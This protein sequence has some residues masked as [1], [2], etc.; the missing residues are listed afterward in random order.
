MKKTIAQRFLDRKKKESVGNFFVVL[1]NAIPE[2]E[3][4][5]GG[6]EQ[7]V[8]LVRATTPQDAESLFFEETEDWRPYEVL[9]LSAYLK[10]SGNAAAE[11]LSVVKGPG[12]VW[13]FNEFT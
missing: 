12:P 9:P 8:H 6:D 11:L 3:D 13:L 4:G 10:E 5:P 7:A 2:E 1:S